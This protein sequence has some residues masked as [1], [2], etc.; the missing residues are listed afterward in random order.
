MQD[1]ML[2]LSH[3]LENGFTPYHVNEIIQAQLLKN[4]F[5][6]LFEEQDWALNIL[7]K[8]RVALSHFA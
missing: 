7:Y 6:P 2:R 8:E 4:G 1:K 5:C 3:C